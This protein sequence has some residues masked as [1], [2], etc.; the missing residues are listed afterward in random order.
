MLDSLKLK[1]DFIPIF[2]DYTYKYFDFPISLHK[3]L[4]I[5]DNINKRGEIPLESYF[6]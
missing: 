4:Q 5:I 3:S 2:I 1:P 6:Y